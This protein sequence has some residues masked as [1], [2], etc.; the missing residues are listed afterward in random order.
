[1][2]VL[3]RRYGDFGVAAYREIVLEAGFV[4]LSLAQSGLASS[5]QCN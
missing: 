1:M 5:S 2:T 3:A 4:G